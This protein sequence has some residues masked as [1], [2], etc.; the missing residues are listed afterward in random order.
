MRPSPGLVTHPSKTGLSRRL[1]PL[2]V[3]R[4][5]W[6]P[7]QHWEQDPCGDTLFQTEHGAPRMADP[8]MH[9]GGLRLPF[10]VGAEAIAVQIS[11]LTCR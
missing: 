5:P 9:Q 8:S 4:T 7:R 2:G 10:K 3:A 1:S 11:P 6:W